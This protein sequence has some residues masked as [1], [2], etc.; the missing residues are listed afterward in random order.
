MVI[1]QGP[2]RETVLR[3]RRLYR[4]LGKLYP[5]AHCELNHE[6]PYQLLVATIL[7]AQCTDIRVN[8]VTPSLFERFPAPSDMA[9]AKVEEVENLIRST[10]FY[11]NKAKS[12]ISSSRDISISH[13]NRVPNTME[14]LLRLKGVARKTANVV[15]G[16]AYG[17]NDGVVVDTHVSRLSTR[18]GLT[19][20]KAPEKIEVDL[21]AL[22]PRKNWCLLSH[23]LIWHGRRV[24]NA[25]RP[26]CQE[27]LVAR[28]CPS[29][30][31]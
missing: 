7:S 10:G 29:S 24:C 17:K 1:R 18:M 2:D 26:R 3:A 21:M 5:D 31:V 16:N 23:L 9:E 8:M 22:F 28:L 19:Q 15:L 25:R 27:C 12:L 4:G 20:E 11:R 13:K 14:E 6:N 30:Q